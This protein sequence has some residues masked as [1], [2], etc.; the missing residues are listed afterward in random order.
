ML[1]TLFFRNSQFMLVFLRDSNSSQTAIDCFHFLLQQL[2]EETFKELF[3]FILTDNGSEF[4]N[5]KALEFSQSG[6]RL[7]RIFYC[8]AGRPSQKGAIEKNHEEIRYVLPKGTSFNH[9]SQKDVNLM[10]DPINSKI[11]KKLNNKYP[12]SLFKLLYGEDI[13]HRLQSAPIA[14][15]E[16]C[17]TPK[18][19]TH[20][21]LE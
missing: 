3:P 19:L 20:K 13:L 12:Y 8:D 2:G 10:M 5:P 14:A 18:L 11:R 1:L 7:V 4:S 21:T 16:V 15:N 6:Q 17:P 9:L